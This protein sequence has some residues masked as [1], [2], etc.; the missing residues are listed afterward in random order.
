MESQTVQPTVIDDHT[1]QLLK[2]EIKQEMLNILSNSNLSKVLEKYGI[3]A[4]DVFKL[5]YTLD[6]NQHQSNDVGGHQQTKKF[7]QAFPDKK[8]NTYCIVLRKPCPIDNN[9]DGCWMDCQ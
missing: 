7:L 2:D 1:L 9:P 8:L 5:Q 4:Q 6:L 3:S